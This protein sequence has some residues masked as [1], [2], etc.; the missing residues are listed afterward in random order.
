ME[1]F[2]PGHRVDDIDDVKA[3]SVRTDLRLSRQGI[4][5]VLDEYDPGEDPLVGAGC[6][7]R[8]GAVR[9]FRAVRA[10][11]DK[12]QQGKG[13][14]ALL[15]TV[16]QRSGI[17]P[18]ELDGPGIFRKD[19]MVV[20]EP[21]NDRGDIADLKRFEAACG[22]HDSFA[23]VKSIVSPGSSAVAAGKDLEGEVGFS[24]PVGK[25]VEPLPD[26]F[27]IRRVLAD[28]AH[29]DPVEIRVQLGREPVF[30]CGQ[31]KTNAVQGR[32]VHVR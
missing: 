19:D 2:V 5:A 18:G 7:K 32:A 8:D 6:G 22:D 13:S 9:M 17:F 16:E 23:V 29:M 31:K 14:T 11:G 26:I 27:G 24:G 3:G 4:D 25:F 21:C 20:P 28:M 15:C 10:L 12:D 30:E 1:V